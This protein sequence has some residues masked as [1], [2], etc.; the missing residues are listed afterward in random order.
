[1]L[2]LLPYCSQRE[3]AKP[4]DVTRSVSVD[5]L[6][7]PNYDNSAEEELRA[8]L[9]NQLVGS[10]LNLL[11]LFCSIQFHP[12]VSRNKLAP[13]NTL[14]SPRAALNATLVISVNFPLKLNSDALMC[15]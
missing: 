9:I 4:T 11:V 6:K 15:P 8:L 2:S 13:R 7:M 5:K 14:A 3:A 10:D 1:M 12:K